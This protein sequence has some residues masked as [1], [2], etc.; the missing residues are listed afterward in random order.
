MCFTWKYLPLNSVEMITCKTTICRSNVLHYV[1]TTC[2]LSYNTH[3][4]WLF[5][6]LC[7]NGP[8]SLSSSMNQH[9]E[10]FCWRAPRIFCAWFEHSCQIS[11]IMSNFLNEF[12]QNQN[13]KSSPDTK[14]NWAIRYLR[15]SR[16]LHFTILWF[17]R[18]SLYYNG[19]ENTSQHQRRED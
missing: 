14:R 10:A 19:V 16:L 4:V 3:W 8:F 13:I 9:T 1:L 2:K 15:P 17:K 6:T 18:A 7:L 11:S 5:T 12:W